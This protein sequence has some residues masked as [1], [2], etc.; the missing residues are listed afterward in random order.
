MLREK[1]QF[2]F[3]EVPQVA[4]TPLRESMLDVLANKFYEHGGEFH[5]HKC[6]IILEVSDKYC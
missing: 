2:S 4:H 6:G 5:G 1:I 3:D